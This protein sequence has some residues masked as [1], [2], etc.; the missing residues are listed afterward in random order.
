MVGPPG[1]SKTMLAKRVPTIL[2]EL[3]A[4]ESIETT[5]IYPEMGPKGKE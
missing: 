5:R 1:S 2:T 4:A 3:T